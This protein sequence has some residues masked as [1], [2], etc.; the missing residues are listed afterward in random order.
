MRSIILVLIVAV[1]VITP[2][3]AKEK[4]GTQTG[5]AS[6]YHKKF[7]GRKTANG[8]RFNNGAFTCAHRKY[9]FNTILKVKRLKTGKV[10]FCRIN[11]RGPFSKGRIIDLS[12]RAARDI[13]L[14]HAG[15]GKVTITKHCAPS[16]AARKYNAKTPMVNCVENP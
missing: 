8:E 15:L 10:T 2:V 3:Y 7:Q 9:Q 5:I 1:S 6:Y 14:I 16:K 4:A 12:Q 11:D 13:G